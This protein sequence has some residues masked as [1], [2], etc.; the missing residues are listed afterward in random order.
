M[1]KIVFESKYEVGDVVAFEKN[2][3]GLIGIVEGYYVDNDEFWYNIRLNNK[4]VL[5]YSN[6]GDVSESAILFKLT[7]EQADLFKKYGCREIDS[8]KSASST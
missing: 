2:D 1:G 6:G 7:D 3:R 8:Y 5:T 4:Y